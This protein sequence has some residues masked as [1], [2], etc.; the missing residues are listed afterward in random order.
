MV[1]SGCGE[2]SSS[3]SP[4]FFEFKQQPGD[5]YV[6]KIADEVH[7]SI[8]DSAGKVFNTHH[9]QEQ[10]SIMKFLAIDSTA[11]R[12]IALYFIITYDSILSTTDTLRLKKRKSRVGEK[13]E[14]QLRMNPNGRIVSVTSANPHLTFFYETA[15]RPSQPAFPEHAIARGYSWTQEFTVN[16]PGGE[17]CTVSAEYQFAGFERVGEFDCAV[18][19]FNSALHY[20]EAYKPKAACAGRED[21]TG[22]YDSRSTSVGKL[23]FAYR[24]G[25]VVKKENLI[26]VISEMAIKSGDKV[27]KISDSEFRDQEKITLDAIYRSSGEKTAFEIK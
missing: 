25:F 13:S 19:A 10:K 21:C 23:Y 9:A 18:I 15:Y 16:V 6:Y 3:T 8:V 26:T 11:V 5:K 14:L 2:N 4:I 20:I 1:L 7:W 22:Q 17:P 12:E 27:T 24:E